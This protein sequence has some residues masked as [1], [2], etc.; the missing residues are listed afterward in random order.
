VDDL[1]VAVSVKS[2]SP[3]TVTADVAI[4]LARVLF[5]QD[6]DRHV[7]KLELAVF[8]SDGR[9]RLVGQRWVTLDLKLTDETLAKLL[10]ERLKESVTVPV[11]GRVRYV[12]AVVYDHGTGRAGAG[13]TEMK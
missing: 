12:K 1:G 13:V 7:A 2:G 10:G 11:T 8:C 3:P 6:A 9:E 5:S 4:D